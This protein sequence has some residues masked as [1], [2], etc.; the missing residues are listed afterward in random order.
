MV[1]ST[2]PRVIGPGDRIEVPVTAFAM[3]ENLGSVEVSIAVQGPLAIV[4]EARKRVDFA[5]SGERDLSFRLQ[6]DQAVGPATAVVEA[7]AT[8]AHASRQTHL[9]V[10]PSSPPIYESTERG[11]TSRRVGIFNRAGQGNARHQPS[12]DQRAPLAHIL[13]ST[14][15]CCAWCAIRTAAWSKPFPRSF[16]NSISRTCSTSSQRSTASSPRISTNA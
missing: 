3:A 12:A 2:L 6:A 5:S 9:E 4:G 11:V 1:L 8:E 14:I 16:P 13:T 15:R 7:T 10:R